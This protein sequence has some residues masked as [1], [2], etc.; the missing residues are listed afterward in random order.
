M[1]PTAVILVVG[2]NSQLLAHAPRLAKFARA[3]AVHRLKPV[4]PAVTC[5]VQASMLTGLTPA[6]HGI[7]GNGWYDRSLAE[8]QFWKQSNQLVQG[9]KIW[10]LAKEKDPSFTCAQ[11]FWWYNMYAD[12]EW[13]VTPRPIY[14][15]DGRKLPD[16]YAN[17]SQLGRQLQE[18]LG[19]FPLFNFWG[20]ASSL[21]SS[22]W[23]AD[24][25]IEVHRQFR[26]TLTLAYLPH[27]DYALQKLGPNHP[28]IPAEVAAVDEQAGKL[29]D[30]FAQQ[31]VA[32]IVLSEYGIEG[33]TRPVHIN[34]HLRAAGLL[35]CRE[36][37]GRELLDAGASAAFS[38]ADHQIAHIYVN[39]ARRLPEVVELCRAIPGV[40][41]VLTGAEKTAAGLDH[42]RCG[43]VVL[44]AAAGSWFSYYYWLDDRRAPDF[45]HMVEIH[46]KPGYDP[47]DL[48]LDPAMPL[49]KLQIA[50]RLF[51]RKMG[52]RTLMNVIP[53]NADLVRGSHGRISQT[54]EQQPILI[55]SPARN[56]PEELPCTAI[57]DIVLESL[58]R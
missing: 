15:A 32:P 39:H 27:L 43:D 1:Q 20:P 3:N 6:G 23:I 44:V 35:A 47:A 54:P 49:P 40:E 11:M 5:S 58:F 51:K 48:F 10:H 33:V 16:V 9:K 8:I 14:K 50:W 19:T 31:Q 24:A 37:Q 55:H 34:R 57:R 21:R 29:L 13:S 28:A 30:Y 7:V 25:T 4:L 45:A 53:L 36:E 38:V 46:R 2:L 41:Q 52:F 22:Q 18:K 42:S 26:P 56:L 17:P 12:V